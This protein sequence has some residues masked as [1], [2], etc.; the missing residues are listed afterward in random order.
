MVKEDILAKACICHDLGGSAKIINNIDPDVSPSICPGPG[1]AD[2]SKVASLEE[3]VGHIY[4]R[5]SLLTNSKRP[6]M[7]IRELK[8]Y[9]DNF[10]K[11]IERYSLELSTRTP[12]YFLEVKENLLKGIEHYRHTANE[13]TKEIH[14]KFLAELKALHDE[15]EDIFLTELSEPSTP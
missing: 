7:F 13:F 9:V 15:L 1:I 12:K 14:T 11:E 4:G 8:I 3:M 10:R 5:L 6:H 2:F